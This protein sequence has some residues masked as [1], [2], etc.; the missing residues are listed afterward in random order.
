MEDFAGAGNYL[1]SHSWEV[2]EQHVGLQGQV[3]HALSFPSFLRRGAWLPVK[4]C[5]ATPG[6]LGVHEGTEGAWALFCLH[7]ARDGAWQVW[8]FTWG[9]TARADAAAPTHRTT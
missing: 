3:S 6:K 1:G 9:W 7:I 8:S 2:V 4:V 5:P